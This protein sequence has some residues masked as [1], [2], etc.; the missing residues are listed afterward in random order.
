MTEP[1]QR[2][3]ECL[4]TVTQGREGAPG[5]WCVACGV[6]VSAIEERPCRGCAHFRSD[7]WILGICKHHG[8]HVTANMLAAYQVAQGTCWTAN[9][10]RAPVAE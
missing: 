9:T 6:Q 8:G 5:Y 4:H 7:G 2:R 10:E 3:D 1:T